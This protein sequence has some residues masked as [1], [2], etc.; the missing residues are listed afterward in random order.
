MA[1]IKHSLQT[2]A[3]LDTVYPLVSSGA[4]LSLWWAEDVTEDGAA[5]ELGFFNRDTVYRLKLQNGKSPNRVEWLCETGKEW[6]G[7]LLVFVLEPHGSGTLVRFTH[8]GWLAETDYFV[9]CNTVWGELMFRLRAAAEGG[10]PGPLFLRD[11]LKY[12]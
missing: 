12:R 2:S 10:S 6:A 7:T 1:D 4:G 3:A 11:G 9:S 5:V 8:S